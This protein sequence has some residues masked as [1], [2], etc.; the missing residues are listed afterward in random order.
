[1]FLYNSGYS[2]IGNESVAL[3]T[4]I[5]NVMF[6]MW[7]I[8]NQSENR[9]ELLSWFEQQCGESFLRNFIQHFPFSAYIET[10]RS[11]KQIGD[12]QCREQNLILCFL[13]SHLEIKS[14]AKYIPLVF[15]YIRGMY[16]VVCK[17]CFHMEL[18]ITQ[19]AYLYLLT[20][21]RFISLWGSPHSD[22]DRT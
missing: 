20:F 14:A 21:I 17:T 7:N 13:W 22:D 10:M 16:M 6:K 9:I 5:T 8:M 2:L 3:L 1:M 11:K 12:P 18:F 19:N 4:C 15:Q